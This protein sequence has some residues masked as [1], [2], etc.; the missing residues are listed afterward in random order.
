[1]QNKPIVIEKILA[2]S[3]AKVWRALT[4]IEELREW[5]P[6]VFGTVEE[7]KA[8]P[9]FSFKFLLGPEDKQF[10]HL[11]EITEV[12][13]GKKL[14]YSWRYD[15]YKGASLITY[16]LTPDGDKTRLRMTWEGTHSFPAEIFAPEGFVQGANHTMT[17]LEAFIKSEE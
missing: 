4:N 3:A 13:E 9:G 14:A 15:G 2:E 1:M 5:N 11:C 8:E 7:F 10:L 12:V 16:E 17:E 6:Y